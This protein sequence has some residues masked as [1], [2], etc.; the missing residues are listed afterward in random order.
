MFN[1]QKTEAVKYSNN[2]RNNDDHSVLDQ[3]RLFNVNISSMKRPKNLNKTCVL[4]ANVS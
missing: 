1:C 3:R 4:F 2:H